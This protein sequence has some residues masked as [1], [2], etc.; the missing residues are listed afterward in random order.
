VGVHGLLLFST[1]ALVH[2]QDVHV[3]CVCKLGP[4]RRGYIAGLAQPPGLLAGDPDIAKRL[5]ENVRRLLVNWMHA[6]GHT[7]QCQL[8]HSGRHT[9]GAGRQNSEGAEQGWAMLKVHG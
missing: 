1:F 2:W 8:N 9:E 7:L 5:A 3:G 4:S 6:E